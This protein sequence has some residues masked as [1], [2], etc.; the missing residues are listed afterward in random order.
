M[1]GVT[2]IGSSLSSEMVGS[3]FIQYEASTFEDICNLVQFSFDFF[4]GLAKDNH[5]IYIGMTGKIRSLVKEIVGRSL[6]LVGGIA[7]YDNPN[8]GCFTLWSSYSM[9]RKFGVWS[10]PFIKFLK[11]ESKSIMLDVQGWCNIILLLLLMTPGSKC[12]LFHDYGVFS[13]DSEKE[14]SLQKN[15]PSQRDEHEHSG[16]LTNLIDIPLSISIGPVDPDWTVPNKPYRLLANVV[17]FLAKFP[18]SLASQCT[19]EW[20]NRNDS[21]NLNDALPCPQTEAQAQADFSYIGVKGIAITTPGGQKIQVD[22]SMLGSLQVH[23]NDTLQ[24]VESDLHVDSATK[25]RIHRNGTSSNNSTNDELLISTPKIGVKMSV[26]GDSLMVNVMVDKSLQRNV[27]TTTLINTNTTMTIQTNNATTPAQVNTTTIIPLI[28]T[29]VPA[30]VNTSTTIPSVNTSTTIPSVN[31]STNIPSVNTSATTPSVNTT[32]PAQF[33]TTTPAQFNT[34]TPAQVNTTI[35]AQI[36]TTTILQVNTTTTIPQ[37]NTT[38]P[39]QLNTTNSTIPQ[40]SDYS[41]S[42][43]FNTC[44]SQHHQLNYSTSQYY[45]TSAQVNSTVTIPQV[46]IST[47]AQV[48]TTN[49]TIP[50]VNTT[51]PAQV[52]ITTTIPEVNTTIPAQFNTTTPA[53]VNTTTPAHVNTTTPAQVNTTT[54]AQVNTTTPAQVNTTAIPQV[55]NTTTNLQVNNTIP[56]QVSTTTTIA[57]VNTTI[58]AQF[59]TTNSTIPQ[60]NTTIPAQLNTTNSTIPQVNAS[61]PAQVNTTNSTIPQVNTSTPAQVNITTTIPEVNNT[62]PAQVN[63]TVTIPQVNISTPAQVNTTNSTIPQVNT[64][65]PAQVNITTIPEVNTTIPVQVSN[66]TNIPQV[67]TTT[68][69]QVNTTTP[70]QVN[71]TTAIPQVNTTTIPQVNTTTIQ[72][73]NTTTISQVNTTTIPGVNTTTIPQVNTTTIPRVNTTTIPQVNTTTISQVNTTTIPQVNTTTIPQVNTT[74]IPQVN[75]TTIPQVNTTTIPQVNTTTLPQVNTT[76]IPQVNTTTPTVQVNTTT[77]VLQVNTST[78]IPQGNTTTAVPQVNITTTIP[79]VI[80]TS[81]VQGNISTTIPPV[82]ATTPAQLNTTTTTQTGNSTASA[83]VSTITSVQPANTTSSAVQVN[84][85]TTTQG[86]A[87]SNATSQQ[88]I[89]TTTPQPI[90]M[91]TNIILGNTTVTLQFN[92]TNNTQS[93]ST[94]STSISNTA[95]AKSSTSPITVLVNTTTSNIAGNVSTTL[96]VNPTTTV[97]TSTSMSSIEGKITSISTSTASLAPSTTSQASSTTLPALTTQISPTCTVT[98]VKGRISPREITVY[99][100][101]LLFIYD[102]RTLKSSTF[103][104]TTCV[105]HYGRFVKEVTGTH[106]ASSGNASYYIIPSLT[107]AGRLPFTLKIFYNGLTCEQYDFNIDVLRSPTEFASIETTNVQGKFQLKWT[108]ASLTQGTV[109]IAYHLSKSFD[110][111]NVLLA[112]ITNNG[113]VEVS[114]LKSKPDIPLT[115]SITTLAPL[116]ESSY[117]T[118]L[119]VKIEEFLKVYRMILT[120]FCDDSWFQTG[121]NKTNDIT[122]CPPRGSQ[123][124]R[125]PRFSRNEAIRSMYFPGMT[126][127]HTSLFP[128]PSGVVQMCCYY[129]NNLVCG[130]EGAPPFVSSTSSNPWDHILDDLLPLNA[131]YFGDDRKK[132]RRFLSKRPS[133]CGRDYVRMV[134]G[135]SFGDPHFATLDG[136]QTY[137]FNGL[138]EFHLAKSNDNSL[139]SVSVRLEPVS[140][141]IK[142][143]VITAVGM[144]C[145]TGPRIHVEPI[146]ASFPLQVRVNDQVVTFSG[147]SQAVDANVMLL[148][149]NASIS[150]SAVIIVANDLG[151]RISTKLSAMQTTI[152]AGPSTYYNKLD[153]LIGKFDG[154]SNNDLVLPNGTLLYA[155]SDLRDLHNFGLQWRVPKGDSP[156]YYTG[157]VTYESLN[158]NTFTPILQRPTVNDTVKEWCKNNLQCLFDYDATGNLEFAKN[159]LYQEETF[160]A[161]RNELSVKTEICLEPPVPPNGY[162]T[163]NTLVAA[164]ATVTFGC[165]DGYSL[166]SDTTISCNA[167]SQWVG[168]VPSCTPAANLSIIDQILEKKNNKMTNIWSWI[169]GVFGG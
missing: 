94:T 29:T 57:Q 138:G 161:R 135:N 9:M 99:G 146:D 165:E 30:Q 97:G 150:D 80:T 40:H 75:T 62:I 149:D 66:T 72:Q 15:L 24:T 25:V 118:T 6:T 17:D 31:I 111:K 55:N 158:N 129:E 156:F 47:P 58:P 130:S 160:L 11:K 139:C 137:T 65:T 43:Y 21:S 35:P 104:R 95:N 84:S 123:A 107:A 1:E 49:S 154:N 124:D 127:C 92:T 98:G 16:N 114:N 117:R 93:G 13:G 152:I 82:N 86:V 121:K 131:C 20:L 77:T 52:N 167:S 100:S 14:P 7:C 148:M 48:N 153:G 56:A 67:I 116:S 105:I 125:D 51:T 2:G 73:V 103:N 33:N 128:S 83:Q 134:V 122:D 145:G 70:A 38:I 85:S 166:R 112:S 106:L 108:Q 54:P 136:L 3:E 8:R 28:S 64:T 42:Q 41:T 113:S 140:A 147:N 5:I 142:A 68:P 61:T 115:L 133:S 78:T 10:P 23:L 126:A 151:I 76:T 102:D 168:I 163:Y 32:T 12:N 120:G 132:R 26:M 90:N 89:S 159:T 91:T 96:D 81:S 119:F 88:I 19:T 22:K 101:G 144:R 155:N 45:N 46:N 69:A 141:V 79:T 169:R 50:Q 4:K 71:T 37:V 27:N 34:T 63:S 87:T 74:T 18:S 39:A 162:A 60:V 36:N 164:N 109:S 44:T 53:Q 157:S 59:N 110:I 143:T